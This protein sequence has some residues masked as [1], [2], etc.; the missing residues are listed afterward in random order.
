M[1]LP[2]D[3]KYELVGG[4]LLHMSPAGGRHGRIIARL[5]AALVAFVGERRL[6][7]VF[8]GQT[9]YRLTA[10]GGNVRSPDL[11]FV[12]AGRLEHDVPTGFLYLAPDLAVEV[13]SPNDRAGDVAQKVAEYLS[14]GVRLLWLIDPDSSSAVV[15]RPGL[16]PRSVKREQSLDGEDVVPGFVQPLGDILQ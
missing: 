2:D 9:G 1:A 10:A 15:Y 7:E 13:L 14:V 3:G 16:A 11:S 8:D 12:A 6:G 4:E 5:T